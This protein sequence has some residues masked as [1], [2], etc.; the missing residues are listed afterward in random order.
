MKRRVPVFAIILA[1]FLLGS[2]AI[3]FAADRNPFTSL[4]A[5]HALSNDEASQAIPVAFEASVT[6]YKKGDVDLF[7]QDGDT[8]IYVETTADANLVTG[9]RVL[10][11]GKT[12]AS[13]R[14]EV[15]SSSVIF[16]HHGIPP[17][18]VRANF[19]QLIRAELDCRR[20]TVRAVVRSANV[21]FEAGLKNIYLQLLM[22]G[23]NI[24]AEMVDSD[25]SKLSE[26]LDSEVEITGAVAGKFDSKMQMTGILLE[27]PSQSDVTILRHANAAPSLLPATPMD[28]ILNNYDIQDRTQRVR[29]QGTVTYYQ[30]GSAIVLE[31]G[32]NS[33]WI[34]TQFE[35]PLKIGESVSATGFPDVHN[36]ALTLS[37]GEIEESG[38]PSPILPL[39]VTASELAL[40]AHA[41]DLVSAEGR[42]LMAVREAAQDEYVVVAGDH[43]FSAVYRHPGHGVDVQLSPMK[44]VALGSKVRM[45]GIC[46]LDNFD[47]FQGPVAFDVLLRSSDDVT[48]VASPS[49]LNVAN[50]ILLVGLLLLVVMAI[51]ARA[52]SIEHRVRQQTTEL[53]KSEQWRSRILEDINGSAPLSEIVEQITAL[54]SLKLAGVSCWCEL[55]DGVRLGN[56]PAEITDLRVVESPIRARSGSPL[57]AVLA[58]F[59][60]VPRLANEAEVLSTAAGLAALAIENRRLYSDLLHRSDFDL[61]TDIHNRF[62]LE[63]RLDEL[64]DES[65]TK[66]GIFGLIYVDLDGFK[67][68]ND[69]YG[70]QVGDFYLQKVA[71]RMKHQVRPGDMLARIGGD[72]F[73]VL[74]PH[75]GSHDDVK[76]IALRLERCFF[77]PF[78]IDGNQLRGSASLG[79]A[80]YPTDGSTKDSLLNSADAAMYVEKHSKRPSVGDRPGASNPDFTSEPRTTRRQ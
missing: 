76:E 58:G 55:A 7:V 44:Q 23:G 73:A 8:A 53:A 17:V 11:V 61:L 15:M 25:S 56:H 79:V 68:I 32:A 9:D 3:G 80:F 2:A 64:I 57:G 21:V 12:R 63:K 31:S 50:L 47:K 38:A 59:P 14:P 33:L 18:P 10:V 54:A 65:R 6:Y 66:R 52:W 30:P 20:A 26:L 69:L 35:Q 16:L 42:L 60:D 74:V 39:P 37:R 40:G 70:H 19:K 77:N 78:V 48:V 49:P 75:V 43:L 34:A 5:I 13:F 27:V 67:L 45:T 46:I 24:D 71:Q 28:E 62:S 36:G 41:F 72:E 51:G 4:R 22:D 1:A 29:V